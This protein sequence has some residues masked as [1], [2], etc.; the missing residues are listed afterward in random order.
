MSK[1]YKI[2]LAVLLV[3]LGLLV[4]MQANQPQPINWSPS[5]SNVDK[6]PLGSKVFFE[7][8][9]AQTN[10]KQIDKV[11]F[12]FLS[13]STISGTYFFLNNHLAFGEAEGNKLLEWVRKGNT[14][15]L[16]ADNFG[17]YLMDTLNL[18]KTSRTRVEDLKTFPQLQLTNQR[19]K[20]SSDSTFTYH[21]NQ[22][23]AYF[24]E[25][26]TTQQIVLG[27]AKIASKKNKKVSKKDQM[28]NF[29]EA[30]VGKGKIYLHLFPEA[31]S[32]FFML[33]EKNYRYA[34]KVLA[35]LPK[36]TPIYWDNH[37]KANE[38]V[39]TS[40]LYVLLNDHALKWAYYFILIGTVLFVFF[41]G[42]RKQKAIS[43]IPPLKNQ[44]YAFTKTIAGMYL[45]KADHTAIA[46]KQITQFYDFVR[47]ELRINQK[48]NQPGFY[49][50]LSTKTGESQEDLKS[51]FTYLAKIDEKVKVDKQELLR[52]NRRITEFKTKNSW[53]KNKTQ[54]PNKPET[55]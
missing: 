14:L 46:K 49:E 40:L 34:E 51:L 24:S 17:S 41:E 5:Y 52:L 21:H 44:T 48:P 10:V 38:T 28:I 33:S 6:I 35:Y 45:E 37:Y 42:K 16:A 3:L 13:D 20:A 12:N 4:Y 30:P 9:K 15:F 39:E 8:L 26:D 55:I 18:K 2:I 1:G 23:L 54:N 36:K 29:I 27:T 7:S 25:I 43:V 32:N 19:L 50:N 47:N 22:P 53:N 31:F 11:P